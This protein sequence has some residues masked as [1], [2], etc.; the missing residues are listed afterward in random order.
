VLPEIKTRYV[1]GVLIY[2]IKMRFIQLAIFSTCSVATLWSLAGCG[3]NAPQ[4][5]ANAAR[6]QKAGGAGFDYRKALVLIDDPSTHATGIDFLTSGAN[7]G[8]SNAQLLLALTQIG[9]KEK[10]SALLIASAAQ[11]NA[12]AEALLGDAYLIGDLLRQDKNEGLRLLQLAAQNGNV[13]ASVSLGE[14]YE[15]A[16]GSAEAAL[17]AKEADIVAQEQ[18]LESQQA[19]VESLSAASLRWSDSFEGLTK[20]KTEILESLHLVDEGIAKDAEAQATLQNLSH[21]DPAAF[22]REMDKASQG[23]PNSIG[24]FTVMVP[25]VGP[26][27]IIPGVRSGFGARDDIS[28]LLERRLELVNAQIPNAEQHK[29][30]QSQE[31]ESERGTYEKMRLL[32]ATSK[33]GLASERTSVAASSSASISQAIKWY[34]FAARRQDV[35]DADFDPFSPALSIASTG[36]ARKD[37]SESALY[38]LTHNREEVPSSALPAPKTV[39]VF[40]KAMRDAVI[41]SRKKLGDLDVAAGSFKEAAIWYALAANEGDTTAQ[42]QLADMYYQGRGVLQDFQLA[43][44]WVNISCTLGN[45][46]A[47]MARYT[48]NQEGHYFYPKPLAEK[49]L[50]HI[51]AHK[52]D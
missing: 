33:S 11:G 51:N 44:M 42:L 37:E 26:Q 34:E 25:E 1:V 8:D 2:K 30:S 24:A 39:R 45:E 40:R 4:A 28:A 7:Q 10:A 31:L 41:S 43:L 46:G 5:E 36:G 9:D 18:A 27:V 17:R 19:K 38:S 22:S 49:I 48:W 15:K 29:A 3:R 14:F 12:N 50:A 47:Q 23:Q 16:N 6:E 20:T 52:T 32:L 13:L 21:V 35:F